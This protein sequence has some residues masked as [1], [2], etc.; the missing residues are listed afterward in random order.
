MLLECLRLPISYIVSDKK[1]IYELSDDDL[2]RLA[3]GAPAES[4]LDRVS[5]AAK[6]IYELNIRHGETKIPMQLVYHTY[7]TYKGWDNKRQAK[8]DFFKDFNKYFEPKRDSTGLYFL[9]DPRSFDLSREE[10]F[11]M[12]ASQRNEKT[13]TKKKSE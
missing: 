10:Y 4:V 7:K 2:I 13:K 12:K 1:I 11:R 9:L 6:F 8:P 3:K 5:E